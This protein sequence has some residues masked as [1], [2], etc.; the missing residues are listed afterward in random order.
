MVGQT[1][2]HQVR[3]DLYLAFIT[4]NQH[5]S[6]YAAGWDDFEL[7][8][9]NDQ[10][11]EVERMVSVKG[12]KLAAGVHMDAEALFTKDAI[13][14]DDSHDEEDQKEATGNEG[15]SVERWYH[16]A[17]VLIWPK[18][19]RLTVL[20]LSAMVK[21]L[22]EIIVKHSSLDNNSSSDSSVLILQKRL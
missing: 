2:R 15:A 5:W 9:F 17:A 1:W 14:E 18:R 3:F 16:K 10:E 4:I 6:A 20:G 12:K 21:K 8:E 7:G 13:D 19:K 11:I 22:E